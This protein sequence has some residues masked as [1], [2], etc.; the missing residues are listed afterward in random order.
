MP[1]LNVTYKKPV[2]TP[3]V[4]LCAAAFDRR[5]RNKIYIRGTIEDGE[6]TVYTTGEGLFVEVMAKL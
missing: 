4:L 6:G 2:P 5:E 3:G 1:D